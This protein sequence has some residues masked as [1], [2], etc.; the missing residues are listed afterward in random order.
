MRPARQLKVITSQLEVLE[1][2]KIQF[3]NLLATINNILQKGFKWIDDESN[4]LSF[5][6]LNQLLTNGTSECLTKCLIIANGSDESGQNLT[7]QTESEEPVLLLST[8][9]SSS[10]TK[11]DRDFHKLKEEISEIEKSHLKKFKIVNQKLASIEKETTDTVLKDI[12]TRNNLKFEEIMKELHSASDFMSHLQSQNEILANSV[13][14]KTVEINDMRQTLNDIKVHSVTTSNI[15]SSNAQTYE[16]LSLKL[17]DNTKLIEAVQSLNESLSA[18]LNAVEC[19]FNSLSAEVDSIKRSAV[20]I[21]ATG[22]TQLPVEQTLIDTAGKSD[23]NFPAYFGEPDETED[24]DDDDDYL[25]APAVGFNACVSEE[26]ATF[27]LVKNEILTC[28]T[29]VT[30]DIQDN[31]DSESGIFT[32]PFDGLYLCGLFIDII[33]FV[34]HDLEFCIYVRETDGTETVIAHCHCRQR[35]ITVSD[36]VIKQ[37]REN[38]ELFVSSNHSCKKLKFSNYSHFMCALIKE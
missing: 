11:E 32:V 12:D 2:M 6:E 1:D 10:H 31:F 24:D 8:S 33:T 23:V 30:E 22:T 37:L 36:V 26:S 4:E 18:K 19:N 21:D 38:D 13:K 20:D 16:G 35:N 7:K 27:D 34:Q 28:F 17:S 3:E 15:N 5:M 14:E 25:D 9:C 29:S